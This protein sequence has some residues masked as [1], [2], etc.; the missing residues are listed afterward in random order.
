MDKEARSETF[1]YFEFPGWSSRD[2]IQSYVE[3]VKD[4]MQD[5]ESKSS[6]DTLIPPAAVDMLHKRLTDQLSQ[7]CKSESLTVGA[8]VP[9]VAYELAYTLP[10]KS[11]RNR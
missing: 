8:I 10:I 4:H 5:Y 6:V 9:P 1:P 11:L 2:S 3:R 7:L